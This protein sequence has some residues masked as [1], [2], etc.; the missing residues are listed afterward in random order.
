MHNE[1]SADC[2]A[3]PSLKTHAPAAAT[4]AVI[5]LAADASQFHVLD[6]VAW[7]YDDTPTAGLLT[8]TIA[9]TTVFSASITDKGPG[10]FNFYHPFYTI[11]KNQAMV[12]TLASGGGSVSGKLNARVR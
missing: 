12:I 2:S 10:I 6:W 7:S 8:I 11:T 9:G 3:L 4:A 1:N 5:T